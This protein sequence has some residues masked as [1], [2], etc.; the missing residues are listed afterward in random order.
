MKD[1]LQ[2]K[3][4]AKLI[5]EDEIFKAF[6]KRARNVHKLFVVDII[7]AATH[8]H[9]GITHNFKR[10]ANGNYSWR[11][12]NEGVGGRW[13]RANIR[14]IQTWIDNS[15]ALIPV[16]SQAYTCFEELHLFAQALTLQEAKEGAGTDVEKSI[17][18][19]G[20]LHMAF[21]D[22][23]QLV[24]RKTSPH[25]I[26]IELIAPP[27]KSQAFTTA[28][29]PSFI[30][31]PRAD[32]FGNV[33][34]MLNY[35]SF[36][37]PVKRE[38]EIILDYIAS[39]VQHPDKKIYWMPIIQGPK[40]IGK[41]ILATELIG[42]LIESKAHVNLSRRGLNST[43]NRCLLDKRVVFFDEMTARNMEGTLRGYIAEDSM[44]IN[45]IG[46][47]TRSNYIG[48]AVVEDPIT[49]G[50]DETLFCLL[51]TATSP[52][53]PIFYNEGVRAF[54]EGLNGIRKYFEARELVAFCHLAA[55]TTF[56]KLVK[57]ND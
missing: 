50:K 9:T 56:N 32:K 35:F 26:S 20:L 38:R 44:A 15:H 51:H 1:L 46:E 7:Y 48:F 52:R 30:D 19:N 53:N 43:F 18:E 40:G 28:L 12:V 8:I 37:F 4:S 14:T 29:E 24:Y 2:L 17:I 36:L 39:L 27:D 16:W 6:I 45:A 11:D 54:R 10:H 34:I 21:Q 23:S 55:P 47:N 49:L 5:T 13:W 41:S 42:N 33:Q 31:E 3:S 22:G 25:E 57:D